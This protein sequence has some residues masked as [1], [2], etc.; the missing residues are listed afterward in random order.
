MERVDKSP[1]SLKT[2]E[3]LKSFTELRN[4]P[5]ATP[6]TQLLNTPPPSPPPLLHVITEAI[7]FFRKEENKQKIMTIN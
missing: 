3:K 7:L 4:N 6:T 5:K 1:K 2:I